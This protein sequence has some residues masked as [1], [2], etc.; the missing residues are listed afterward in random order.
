MSFKTNSL[1]VSPYQTSLLSSPSPSSYPPNFYY[2]HYPAAPSAAYA[3]GGTTSGRYFDS[4]QLINQNA[5]FINS[6]SNS[7]VASIEID[8]NR[9]SNVVLKS[10]PVVISFAA[11]LNTVSLL[12]SDSCSK[13]FKDFFDL[14]NKIKR[15]LS[16]HLKFI[17]AL[18]SNLERSPAINDGSRIFSRGGGRIFKKNRKFCQPFFRLT[19][20]IFRD[21]P[22]H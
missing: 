7:P 14:A 2:N 19:K 10:T 4:N 16:Y 17:H 8:N 22:K 15:I 3:L 18:S 11:S 1:F 5:A 21:L 6:Q 12:L 20:L 9:A 13:L